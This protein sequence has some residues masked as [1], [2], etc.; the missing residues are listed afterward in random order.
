MT[1]AQRAVLESNMELVRAE[2]V[3]RDRGAE[4]TAE[5]YGALVAL[6]TGS[7]AEGEKATARRI[8]DR[9]RRKAGGA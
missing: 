6:V 3:L 7:K 9:E 5:S 4:L 8:L 1:A 2:E